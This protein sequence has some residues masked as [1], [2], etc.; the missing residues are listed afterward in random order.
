MIGKGI[1]ASVVQVAIGKRNKLKIE[2]VDIVVD[3]GKIIN[4][5]IVLSQVEGS[6]VMGI[7]VALKEEITF[8]N[9]CVSQSNYDDY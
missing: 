7:S 5:D 4:P 8:Q 1:V 9:G 2:K 3:F 6:V